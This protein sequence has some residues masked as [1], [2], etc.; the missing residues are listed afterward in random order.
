LRRIY[1]LLQIRKPSLFQLHAK[2]WTPA[3]E[4]EQAI[5]S[6]VWSLHRSN[7]EL[8]AERILFLPGGKILGYSH[9]NE[10]TWGLVNGHLVFRSTAEVTTAVS[11]PL[12]L[13]Q[14]G[15]LCITMMQANSSEKVAH[16]LRQVGAVERFGLGRGALVWERNGSFAFKVTPGL[17]TLFDEYR[18][19]SQPSGGSRWKLGD[20]VEAPL[21]CKLRRYCGVYAGNTIPRIG[22]FSYLYS[23]AER[24]AAIG[25]YCSI[26]GNVRV[27]GTSHPLH[28]VTSSEVTYQDK[29]R[30][31]IAMRDF[32]VEPDV[33]FGN[34]QRGPVTIENDVWIGQDVILSQ[35]ITLGTGCVVA[36]GAVVT[37]DVPPYAVVGG[38][39]AKVLRYRFPDQLC[40]RLLRSEWWRYA[41]P[42]LRDLRIDEPDA[43]LENLNCAV[44]SG[45]IAPWEPEEQTLF[46]LVL[47]RA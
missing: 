12:E 9:P 28:Y 24:I 6:Q 3:V 21:D 40:S 23:R 20:I 33:Y 11:G 31:A 22:S 35:G 44:A 30:F 41:Y 7:G 37:R 42:H 15:R 4:L 34:P 27:M 5:R 39:P 16:T 18:I 26:A 14:D 19:Y 29:T 47:E 13:K 45:R 17:L 2:Y 38:V 32:G 25:R 46:D 10:A 43:F 36:A 1:D 8:R